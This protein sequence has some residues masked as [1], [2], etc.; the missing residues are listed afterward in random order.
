MTARE[1][2]ESRSDGPAVAT[3]SKSSSID[4]KSHNMLSRFAGIH[5]YS[6]SQ[7]HWCPL[8]RRQVSV[9]ATGRLAGGARSSQKFFVAF[10]LLFKCIARHLLVA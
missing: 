8:E 5:H 7:R 2:R 6:L 9:R 4:Q 10:E 3:R 1:S